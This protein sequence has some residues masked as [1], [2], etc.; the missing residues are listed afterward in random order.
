VASAGSSA[1]PPPRDRTAPVVSKLR[2]VGRK[3][4]FTLSEA[5]KVTIRVELLTKGKKAKT[6]K[7]AGSKPAGRLGANKATFPKG[8]AR[9]RYRVTITALD[10]AGN[11]SK[12][13][14][15]GFAVKR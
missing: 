13:V 4:T 15:L 12:A 7:R 14:K 2:V 6:V 9:G 1:L 3:L 8:L 11:R 5:A 10:A